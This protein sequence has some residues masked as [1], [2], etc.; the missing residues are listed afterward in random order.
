MRSESDLGRSPLS[1]FEKQAAEYFFRAGAEGKRL[2]STILLLMASSLSAV[3]LHPMYLT[4]DESPPAA[5]PEDPR[6]RQQRL[7]GARVA[8]GG[9]ASGAWAGCGGGVVG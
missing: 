5:H 9:R 8:G 3:P 2:R 7:A 6:R 1:F 4:V